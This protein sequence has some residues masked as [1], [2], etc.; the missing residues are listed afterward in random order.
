[1]VRPRAAPARGAFAMGSVTAP[2]QNVKSTVYLEALKGVPMVLCTK[3][4]VAHGGNQK[5]KLSGPLRVGRAKWVRTDEGGVRASRGKP[6]EAQPDGSRHHRGSG[7]P[8][9]NSRGTR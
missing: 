7:A 4:Y 3:R 2:F 1:V 5:K 8:R 9:E 6:W